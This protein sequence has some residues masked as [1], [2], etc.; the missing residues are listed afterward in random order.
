MFIYL[1]LLDMQ[2]AISI[3]RTVYIIL[4]LLLHGF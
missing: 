2:L 3:F 4:M 1:T